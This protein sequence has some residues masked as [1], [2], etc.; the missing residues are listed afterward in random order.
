MAYYPMTHGKLNDAHT[1]RYHGKAWRPDQPNVP[2]SMMVAAEL[3]QTEARDGPTGDAV[4]LNNSKY[5]ELPKNVTKP[6]SGD[7]PRSICLWARI[8]EWENDARIFEYG[9]KAPQGELFGL[10]TYNTPG[11]FAILEQHTKGA[12]TNVT[13]NLTDTD[14]LVAQGPSP[15]PT[16]APSLAPTP[17]PTSSFAP[18][19]VP[20]SVPSYAPTSSFP[21]AVPSSEPT[22]FPTAVP[23]SARERLFP[24]RCRAP[25]QRT[26]ACEPGLVEREELLLRR[27]LFVRPRGLHDAGS[28]RRA[29]FCSD[30]RANISSHGGTDSHA[31]EPGLVEREELPYGGS[32]SYGHA[33]SMTLDPTGVPSSAPT[34]APPS[35][36][37]AV[38]DST[39]ASPDSSSA[40]SYSY[41]GSY[42]YGHADSMTLDPTGVPSSA[43]T[44][45]PT[46][47]PTAVPTPTLASPDSSSA[48]SYSYGGSYSYGHADSM[49][50]D[51]TGVPSSAPTAAPT[52][53][54]TAVPTP[55][56]ASPD[57]SSAKSY[58]YGGSYSYGHADSGARRWIDRGPSSAPSAP[59]Q[60][61][62]FPRK[63]RLPH[64]GSYSYDPDS[65]SA[66]SYSYGGSYSYSLH[67][68]RQWRCSS[69]IDELRLERR[70]RASGRERPPRRRRT[71]F[72]CHVEDWGMEDRPARFLITGSRARFFPTSACRRV[73]RKDFQDCLSATMYDGMFY[74]AARP[75]RRIVEDVQQQERRVDG[76][77][78]QTEYHGVGRVTT[79]APAPAASHERLILG[80]ARA[81]LRLRPSTRHGGSYS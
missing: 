12:Y 70:C 36:P 50:L 68:R 22:Y 45:A 64:G 57:S 55:T 19:S 75:F 4:A 23:S 14:R 67:R 44:A 6:I 78:C 26:D 29:V 74:S 39:L 66:K 52:S 58:S 61:Q 35:L 56:L 8:D 71:P 49:T 5:I 69:D 81:I 11:S 51:P 2:N 3:R 46:S 17:V 62:L 65:S 76:T 41:G 43:P 31:C 7:Q 1:S 77:V 79:M 9:R 27:Q 63:Y 34:A 16:L 59:S 60:R 48:K 72:W 32:Y 47:L 21:T 54:P 33:D 37:T 38:P 10:R 80:R 25:R 13:V 28:D 42:S 18:T 24:R 40:K 53:L 30:G 20:T 73:P 15:G